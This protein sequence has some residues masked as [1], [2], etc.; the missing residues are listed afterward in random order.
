MAALHGA[1]MLKHLRENGVSPANIQKALGKDAYIALDYM[2]RKL[3]SSPDPA[4][5]DD[6]W[7]QALKMYNPDLRPEFKWDGESTRKANSWISAAKAEY[8][9]MFTNVKIPDDMAYELRE[10]AKVK[11][12][13][14][15]AADVAQ[16]MDLAW[17]DIVVDRNMWGPSRLGAAN[18]W[19]RYPIDKQYKE[20]GKNIEEQIVQNIFMQTG[21]KVVIGG[22]E[23]DVMQGLVLSGTW[24][25]EQNKAM[26]EFFLGEQDGIRVSKEGY[27]LA[28]MHKRQEG[29]NHIY[30]ALI[31]TADGNVVAL[32]DV[33][34]NEVEIDLTPQYQAHVAG[35]KA[36]MEIDSQIADLEAKYAYLDNYPLHLGRMSAPGYATE[37]R[38][39]ATIRWREAQEDIAALKE[40]K[41]RLQRNND[42]SKILDLPLLASMTGPNVQT[43]IKK[44]R[45]EIT[46]MDENEYYKFDSL[47]KEEKI[48][49]LRDNGLL[50]E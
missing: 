17:N 41:N 26:T 6:T 1:R 35:K 4:I 19:T 21:G 44:I 50:M 47:T 39:S 27:R 14:G 9:G 24:G 37:Q 3:S 5:A 45:D 11:I 18:K 16:A 30:K 10:A 42:A 28:I 2:Q 40:I 49:Y 36:V 33:N 15:D 13:E 25:E 48:Q 43:Q 23:V 29:P 22:N 7:E 32:E 31:K 46:T 34:G 38:M 8:P 12:Q 20:F